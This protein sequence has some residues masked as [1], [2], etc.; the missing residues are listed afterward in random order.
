MRLSKLFA[1]G[2]A[3][4][5]STSIFSASNAADTLKVAHYDQ[6]AQMGMPYGTFGANGAYQLY[7][8][9]DG[10][11]FVDDDKKVYPLLA[12]EWKLKDAN[13]WIV[14][15]RKGVTFHNGVPWNADAMLGNVD[16]INNDPVVSKQQARRQ[17]AT[18]VSGKKIDDYT[19]ELTTKVPD[20]VLPKRLHIMRPHEPKAWADLGPKGYAREPVGTGSYKIVKWGNDGLKMTAYENAWRK[21][22][23]KNVEITIIPEIAT[24]VQALNSGQ[25]HIAWA[26]DTGAMLLLV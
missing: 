17:L 7:A 4:L 1:A 10:L 19:V 3:V 21:P 15:L 9:F 14:K 2:V 24:R 5:F 25:V 22:K 26:L 8:I 11:T 13:T 6:P 23:T 18:I 16:A 12:T 20:P